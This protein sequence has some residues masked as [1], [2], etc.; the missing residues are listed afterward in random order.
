[1]EMYDAYYC[2]LLPRKRKR[3]RETDRQTEKERELIV[4]ALIK[5]KQYEILCL[6]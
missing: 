5:P 6:I 2:A 3:E 1:M 4:D